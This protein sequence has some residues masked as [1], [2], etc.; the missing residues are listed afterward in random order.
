MKWKA[1]AQ[2]LELAIHKAPH[3]GGCALTECHYDWAKAGGVKIGPCRTNPLYH[4]H[5]RHAP[6]RKACTCWKSAPAVADL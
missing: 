2:E 6:V 4:D 3:A 1:R 5:Y